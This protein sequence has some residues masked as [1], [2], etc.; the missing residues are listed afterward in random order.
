MRNIKFSHEY[1]KMP[2]YETPSRLIQL[3]E[4]DRKDLSD[5]F[6]AYDTLAMNGEMYKLPK[7]KLIILFLLSPSKQLWTTIR[8]YTPSKWDYYQSCVGDLFE[9]VIA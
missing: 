9:I 1:T 3:V 4:I 6:I 8:R 5:Q 2:A 7:G